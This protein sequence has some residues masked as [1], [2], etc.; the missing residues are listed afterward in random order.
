MVAGQSWDLSKFTDIGADHGE[1]VGNT[2]GRQPEFMRPNQ[3]ARRGQGRPHLGMGAGRPLSD[4]R[5]WTS[6]AKLVVSQRARKSHQTAC[7]GVNPVPRVR[8]RGFA[9][10]SM[11]HD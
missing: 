9:P 10:W 11:I 6:Q 8:A 1:P 5:S 2:R 3:S 7:F 4:G